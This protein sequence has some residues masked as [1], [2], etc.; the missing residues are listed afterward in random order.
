MMT[1]RHISIFVLLALAVQTEAQESAD[2]VGT[3]RH[4]HQI[5]VGAGILPVFIDNGEALHEMPSKTVYDDYQLSKYSIGA[6]WYTPSYDINY[7]YYYNEHIAVGGYVAYNHSWRER[8][9]IAPNA[10]D[11]RYNDHHVTFMVSARYYERLSVIRNNLHTTKNGP[12]PYH[13]PFDCWLYIGLAA[14][15]SDYIYRRYDGKHFT[16]KLQ[17]AVHWTILGMQ[18]GGRLYGFCEIGVGALGFARCGAGIKL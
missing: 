2:S 4:R 12:I 1:I 15:G 7:H 13:K 11:G 17:G 6:H 18:I 3:L 8:S 9:A 14:G 16:H 5:E 10:I